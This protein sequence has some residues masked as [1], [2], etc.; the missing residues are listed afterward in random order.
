MGPVSCRM[1]S[2]WPGNSPDPHSHSHHSKDPAARHVQVSTT[3]LPNP[4]S[5]GSELLF[6]ELRLS[7]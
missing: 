4:R 3:E 2:V 1:D 5:E 7:G 6:Y